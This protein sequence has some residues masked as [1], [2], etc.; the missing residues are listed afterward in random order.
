MR[1]LLRVSC[2][3]PTADEGFYAETL[4][5]G[6]MTVIDDFE[7]TFDIGLFGKC[8]RAHIDSENRVADDE[9]SNAS[10]LYNL[11]DLDASKFVQMW[12][13]VQVRDAVLLIIR[14]R[15]ALS[16]NLNLV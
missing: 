5:K 1:L 15:E 14:G 4:S 12:A 9:D 11:R 8:V 10:N 3:S 2:R 16:I 6:S 7:Q 13:G